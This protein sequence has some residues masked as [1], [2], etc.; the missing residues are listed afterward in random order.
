MSLRRVFQRGLSSKSILRSSRRRST[1]TRLRLFVD[2]LEEYTA[3]NMLVP[4]SLAIGIGVAAAA[5]TGAIASAIADPAGDR[6]HDGA[7]AMRSGSTSMVRSRPRIPRCEA[8]VITPPTSGTRPAT[9][10]VHG[11]RTAHSSH[12]KDAFRPKAG[13]DR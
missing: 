3:P 6:G 8:R 2:R 1:S 7:G 4:G 10:A 13:A 5:T 11:T 9:G 12:P